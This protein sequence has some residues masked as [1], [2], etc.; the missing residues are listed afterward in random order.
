MAEETKP[1]VIVEEQFGY[2]CC[3]SEEHANM[4]EAEFKARTETLRTAIQPQGDTW[5]VMAFKQKK[6]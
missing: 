1:K 6:N 3:Y 2:A 5:V 4:V